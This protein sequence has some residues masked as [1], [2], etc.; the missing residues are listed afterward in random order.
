MFFRIKLYNEY[1]FINKKCNHIMI[2]EEN[3][4]CIPIDNKCYK[5]IYETLINFFEREIF[6]GDNK[7]F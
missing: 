7:V 2:K 4:Y 5:N 1:N 6:Y 3:L